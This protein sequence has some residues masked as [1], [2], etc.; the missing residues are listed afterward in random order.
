LELSASQN[1]NKPIQTI[2]IIGN[3]DAG[4]TTTLGH[5]LYKC[6]CFD[7]ALITQFETTGFNIVHP[8]LSFQENNLKFKFNFT[9]FKNILQLQK[10]LN[11]PTDLASEFAKFLT[12]KYAVH[13][14]DIPGNRKNI[15]SLIQGISCADAAI[16]VVSADPDEF[17]RGM[18]V[19][20]LKEGHGH[21]RDSGHDLNE[22]D[23]EANSKGLTRDHLSILAAMGVKQLTVVINKMEVVKYAQAR[24]T[25]IV[26]ELTT[27]L[28]RL[29][30]NVKSVAFIPVSGAVGD[31]ITEVSANMPWFTGWRRDSK[32]G[33][34]LGKGVHH[35]Q[36]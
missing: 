35:S 34:K 23:E 15:I 1:L 12:S 18:H 26:Q 7:P 22:G 13:L 31:N 17:S 5:L 8:G 20:N 6:G 29:G 25:A 21:P 14:L 33:E 19:S 32:S 24:F 30:Y 9:W 2:I 11:Q 28:K 27:L 36:C 10:K 4:K 16:L 3:E